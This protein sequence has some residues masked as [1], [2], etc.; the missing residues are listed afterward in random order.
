MYYWLVITLDYVPVQFPYR[1]PPQLINTRF[2]MGSS[3]S[4]DKGFISGKYPMTKDEGRILLN[5]YTPNC[6]QHW[7][8]SSW[9]I[10]IAT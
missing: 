4:S 5:T 10:A 2:T 6:I 8:K 7:F 1:Q 3:S 9:Y